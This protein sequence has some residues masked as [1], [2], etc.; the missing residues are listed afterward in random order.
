MY[1]V[2]R[3][4]RLYLQKGVWNCFLCKKYPSER[5]PNGAKIYL[6]R[7]QLLWQWAR[8]VGAFMSWTAKRIGLVSWCFLLLA[9]CSWGQ[10]PSTR[11]GIGLLRPVARPGTTP[12]RSGVVVQPEVGAATIPGVPVPQVPAPLTMSQRPSAPP[13]VSYQNGLLTIVAQNSTLG[14]ILREVHRTTGAAIDVPANA[15]ERVVTKIGPGPAR[16]VLAT[17]LNGSTFNYVMVGSAS[18][19][20]SLATVMLTGRP[21]GAGGETAANVNQPPPQP[22]TPQQS[23]MAPGTG[24]GGQPVVQPAAGDEEADA[25]EKDEEDPADEDQ[26]QNQA[27]NGAVPAPDG[28]QPNAG[29]KTPE[30]ILE[31]LRQRPGQMVAPG[32][33]VIQPNGQQP[34]QQTNQDNND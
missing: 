19:P 5:S 11:P 21:A 4:H 32:Q 10:T 7:R 13:Q 15:T 23:L 12:A 1:G 8:A 18:D 22:Y 29:P 24:P 25:E 2:K 3:F 26:A 34:P 20:S 17:L 28:S 27:Q 30:Q 16:E 9:A 6:V 31:M 33:Q 14:D